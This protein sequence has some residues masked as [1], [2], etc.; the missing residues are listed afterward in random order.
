MYVVQ[1]PRLD[2]GSGAYKLWEHEHVITHSE[3]HFP[4]LCKEKVRP[5][6]HEH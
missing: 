2:P 3:F 4:Q 5:A 6:S 1:R